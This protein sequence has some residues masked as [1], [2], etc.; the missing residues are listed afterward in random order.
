MS[1]LFTRV[2]V[3]QQQR[4]LIIPVKMAAA[5]EFPQELIVKALGF[6]GLTGLD[7]LYN[8][9]HRA[10]WDAFNVTR[11]Q[12]KVLNV[13]LLSGDYEFPRQRQK[14]ISGFIYLGP[15]LGLGLA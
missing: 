2:H 4:L 6:V 9:V 12:E 14:V 1:A 7:V 5:C 3:Q 10:I 8:A 11:R 15:G 13:Q